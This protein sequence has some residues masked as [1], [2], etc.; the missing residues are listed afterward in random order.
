MYL[1]MDFMTIFEFMD[2]MLFMEFMDFKNL[3]MKYGF[4]N[5]E[6]FKVILSKS[7]FGLK[8]GLLR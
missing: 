6:K 7:T 5:F 8:I 2:F 4:L 3:L 1:L